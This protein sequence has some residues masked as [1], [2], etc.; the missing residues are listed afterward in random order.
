MI[1]HVR[2]CAAAAA[3]VAALALTGCSSDDGGKRKGGDGAAAEDGAKDTTTGGGS[4]DTGDTGDSGAGTG[5]EGG[6]DG[7][8]VSVNG[9]KSVVLSV[10]QGGKVAV[11]GELGQGE[12]T[13]ATCVG[14]ATATAIDLKCQGGGER[15]TGKVESV[16]A[17]S[18]TVAWEGVGV[19]E[20]RKTDE[21]KLPE[22]MPTDL[23]QGIPQS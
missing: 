15:E 2:V 21:G 19:D 12:K 17:T 18:L 7:L 14:T 16:D 20:F 6:I 23:P 10:Q 3:V 13:G 1:K 4:D 11:L 5:A 22:G 9:G 8:W